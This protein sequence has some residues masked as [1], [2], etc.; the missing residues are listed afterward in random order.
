MTGAT[1]LGKQ[2]TILM[3]IILSEG[4]GLGTGYRYSRTQMNKAIRKNLRVRSQRIQQAYE[5]KESNAYR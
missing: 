2:N 3:G 5:V 4:V 1:C